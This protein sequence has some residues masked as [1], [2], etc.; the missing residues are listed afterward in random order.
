LKKKLI[1]YGS[2]GL[3]AL[4]KNVSDWSSVEAV[5]VDALLPDRLISLGAQKALSWEVSCHDRASRINARTREVLDVFLREY[6]SVPGLETSR[7]FRAACLS[8]DAWRIVS[9]YLLNM[10]MARE[11]AASPHWTEIIV[12]PGSGVSVLA[13]QQLAEHL[14]IPVTVLPLDRDEPPWFWRL[15]QKWDR[16][17]FRKKSSGASGTPPRML[18][19]ESGSQYLCADPRLTSLLADSEWRLLPAL[20]APSPDEQK[21]WVDMYLAWW[22][23]WWRT[24]RADK[25]SLPALEDD[26]RILDTLGRH[27]C[28][29]I[30]SLH[31]PMLMEARQ[32]LAGFEPRF[33][34]SGAMRGKK[35]LMYVLAAR[36]RG[37]PNG[38]VTLDDGVDA[39][40]SFAPNFAFC[41]DVR[42][43]EMA[44]LQG[45]KADQIVMIRSPRMPVLREHS[46]QALAPGRRARIIMADTFFIGAWVA[47]LP[48]AGLWA[49]RLVVEAARLM[50]EHDFFIKLHPIR[51]RPV[52]KFAWSG[53]HHIHQ[54]HRELALKQMSLPTNVSILSPE[55]KLGE[56]LNEADLLLN[57]ESYAGFEAFAAGIPVIHLARTCHVFES[58]AALR[59]L[60]CEQWV[61]EAR[62]LAAMIQRNLHVPGHISQQLECQREFLRGFYSI[63]APPLALAASEVLKAR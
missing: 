28:E 34:M 44:L 5:E 43:S 17:R 1:I 36:E 4:E 52:E 26:T 23:D 24:H 21:A 9:P 59:C 45:M 27:S 38:A 13:W 30:Y 33:L 40:L 49:A 22:D 29:Y 16:K 35:E 57:L 18:S 53:F 42:Q 2:F 51:E 6:A 3:A 48:L 32:R 50:P 61:G 8:L 31:A 11:L 19:A 47:A 46:G 25:A 39:Q 12:S 55:Q 63:E 60:G 14:G 56:I 37:T 41:D 15:R 54:W 10:E 58:L 62:E 7:E 20:S